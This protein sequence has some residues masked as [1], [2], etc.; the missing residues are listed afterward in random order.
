MP[1]STNN[2]PC[3]CKDAQLQQQTAQLR[4][5]DAKLKQQ[6]ALLEQKVAQLKQKDVELQHKDEESG[7]QYAIL[8]H[9]HQ[10]LEQELNRIQ[11]VCEG[12][13]LQLKWKNPLSVEPVSSYLSIFFTSYP[14]SFFP[15]IAPFESKVK[16]LGVL[17]QVI[18]VNPWTT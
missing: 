18:Q 9:E 2:I 12:D 17:K 13:Q 1:I 7:R 10:Q 15:I 8:L 16:M 3:Y 14:H 6:H 5:Q 11:Y 4:E